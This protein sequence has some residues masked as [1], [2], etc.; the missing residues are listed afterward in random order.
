MVASVASVVC[1]WLGSFD[2][3][4]PIARYVDD[5]G[6]V[7]SHILGPDGLDPSVVERDFDWPTST[8]LSKLTV[9]TTKEELKGSE[10]QALDWLVSQ[11]ATVKKIELPQRF[12]EGA[13]TVM[14]NVE[15]ATVF[16]DIL[17]SD[18]EADLGLWP[19]S[20]RKSQY[21]PAIQYLRACRLRTQLI[22]ETEAALRQV[23]VLLGAG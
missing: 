11:G 22:T 17:R 23:D 21:V 14:L 9:G 19:D 18:P 13:M 2:K 8:A 15:A 4:G 5:L 7:F 12:P 6:V 1:L 20:F 10:K 16:D 3:L